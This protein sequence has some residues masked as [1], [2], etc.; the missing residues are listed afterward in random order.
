MPL[1]KEEALRKNSAGK[2]LHPPPIP[3]FYQHPQAS[4]VCF[5][6]NLLESTSQVIEGRKRPREVPTRGTT[7]KSR[8]QG[9]P[10]GIRRK[11][12]PR[13]EEAGSS[14]GGVCH[15]VVISLSFASL[16]TTPKSRPGKPPP[17][18]R[19]KALPR[20]EEAGPSS[21][22]VSQRVVIS[23]SSASEG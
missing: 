8:P 1:P 16:G 11:K 2:M 12:L 15:R 10:P 19:R 13:G 17:S 4:N 6:G 23:S 20:G 5:T 14:S 3:E 9:P 7:P 22:R 21:G 18:I